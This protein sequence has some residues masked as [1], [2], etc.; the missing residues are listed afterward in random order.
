MQPTLTCNKKQFDGTLV[1]YMKWSRKQP[2]EIINAKLFFI[3]LQATQTTQ[4]AN[5]NDIRSELNQP[6]RKFPDKTIG[7][8][9]V[10]G[11]LTRRGKMYKKA[12]T[13]A[14]H[15]ATKVEKLIKRRINA[16]GFLATGWFP[17]VRKLQEAVKR[18]DINFSRR[19]APKKAQGVKFFGN[20]KGDVT[21]ARPNDTNA[22]GTIY[23]YIGQIIGK[24]KKGIS[25]HLKQI[26]QEGLD[27]AVQA[28]V[29]SMISYIRNKMNAQHDKMRRSGKIN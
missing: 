14:K 5:P 4:K 11:D 19:Y 26:L 29:S 13:L 17:A 6:A 7:E 9:I 8:I 18:G 27:K 2:A 15:L 22:R 23:N 3:A 20:D 10:M 21:P 12:K 25:S 16:I 28:E 24:G 1:E